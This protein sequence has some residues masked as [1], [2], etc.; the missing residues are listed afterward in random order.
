VVLSVFH[1]YYYFLFSVWSPAYDSDNSKQKEASNYRRFTLFLVFGGLY[2]GSSNSRQV[3]EFKQNHPMLVMLV[4]S[5]AVYYLIFQVK[6]F[7][8]GTCKRTG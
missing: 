4:S 5:V 1:Y 8:A 2:Y 3:A 6:G 7:I